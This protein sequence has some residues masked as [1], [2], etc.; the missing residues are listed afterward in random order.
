MKQKKRTQPRIE[1]DREWEIY[2][3][4]QHKDFTTLKALRGS[5]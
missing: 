4:H 5:R 2:D 3:Y 1:R